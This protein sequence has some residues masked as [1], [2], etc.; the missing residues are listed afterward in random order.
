MIFIRAQRLQQAHQIYLQRHSD[1][2]WI[3]SYS[4]SY[5]GL[6]CL[7]LKNSYQGKSKRV[8]F[9]RF[10]VW[11]VTPVNHPYF[12]ESAIGKT[13]SCNLYSGAFSVH[14]KPSIILG[15]CYLTNWFRWGNWRWSVEVSKI[16]TVKMKAPRWLPSIKD[17]S[18]ELMY[19]SP[20]TSFLS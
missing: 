9:N 17:E 12:S 8:L 14:A 19:S 4:I 15:W 7:T 10:R 6:K 13:R 16:T 11:L 5:Q 18:F 1:F 2:D 3:D 20:F